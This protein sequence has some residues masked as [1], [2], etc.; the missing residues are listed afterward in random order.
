MSRVAKTPEERREVERVYWQ[1]IS[2]ILL[3]FADAERYGAMP[4]WL[5]RLHERVT[6]H[7]LPGVSEAWAT[8]SSEAFRAGV[9]VGLVS[10]AVIS[11]NEVGD[12]PVR[13][14][15]APLFAMAEALPSDASEAG[16]LRLLRKEV[17]E[18]PLV[19]QGETEL[20]DY[21]KGMAVIQRALSGPPAVV[22]GHLSLNDRI[23]VCLCTSW[24][25]VEEMKTQRELRRRVAAA[26][27]LQDEEIVRIPLRDIC[28]SIGLKFRKV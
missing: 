9:L 14:L 16:L 19:P 28:H 5:Q 3:R 26:L 25:K 17:R 1:V 4:L 15:L 21:Q 11:D 7:F 10:L 27:E 23:A 8:E 12:G 6:P 18:N 22:L 20:R 13:E 2:E 24:R